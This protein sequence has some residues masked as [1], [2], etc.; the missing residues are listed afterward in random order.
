MG[1]SSGAGMARRSTQ[2]RMRFFG[3]VQGVYD[4]GLTAYSAD[5]GTVS[6]VSAWG[7]QVRGGV[8][9][10]KNW[11][12]TDLSLNYIGGYRAYTKETG[13]NGTDQSLMVGLSHNFSPKMFFQTSNTG[14]ILQRA[15]GWGFGYLTPGQTGD[16]VFNPT[17]GQDI[18]DS[19]I[20]SVS[21]YNTLGYKF[22][23]RLSAAASGGPFL[24]KRSNSLVS[25]FGV[26]A[27][28]DVSYRLNR[29]NTITG[30]YA[31]NQMNFSG[32]YG[33]SAVNMV[34]FGW[35][36][37]ARHWELN[38]NASGTKIE[39]DGAEIV[40][41]DPIIAAIVGTNTGLRAFHRV[42][43]YPTFRGVFNTRL[44]RKTFGV[45]GYRQVTPGN[46]VIL[47]SLNTGATGYASYTGIHKWTMSFRT[48]VYQYKGL[49][50][51][52]NTTTT[53]DIGGQAGY[54]VRRDLQAILSVYYRDQRTSGTDYQRNG[55]RIAIGLNYSPGDVPLAL[56]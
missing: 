32:Q 41:L 9:G 1:R 19:T 27:N 40:Q 44:P 50:R 47:T 53:W 6:N 52:F 46:G 28:G 23:P 31:F 29:T 42:N 49:M 8:Y 38:L 33:N 43:Y 17:P 10:V 24:T 51:F 14:S 37:Q 21:N 4:S 35:G 18:Y 34:S 15:Y 2:V 11:R 3:S 25:S 48:G 30:A 39:S 7:V 45:T 56:W 20:Y 12:R 55:V 36:Y 13:M 54:Q 5:T 16:P 22:T 26:N